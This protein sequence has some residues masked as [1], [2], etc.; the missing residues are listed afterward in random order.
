MRFAVP[1]NRLIKMRDVR[2]YGSLGLTQ[3]RHHS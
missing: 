2:F 1:G 3:N